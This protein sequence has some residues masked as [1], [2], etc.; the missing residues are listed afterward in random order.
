MSGPQHPLATSLGRVYLYYIIG[1]A[2][3]TVDSRNF[4]KI[5]EIGSFGWGGK[6]DVTGGRGV[7]DRSANRDE[8]KVSLV[9]IVQII[10]VDDPQALSLQIAGKAVSVQSVFRVLFFL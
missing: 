7:T 9:A 10:S 1:A 5:L 8:L 2:F 6:C 4:S 3:L